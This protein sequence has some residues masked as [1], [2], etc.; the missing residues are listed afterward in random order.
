MNKTYYLTNMFL[1]PILDPI[2][3]HKIEFIVVG[4]DLSGVLSD[5][6]Q[7]LGYNNLS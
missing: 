1:D 5:I 7:I 3:I 2:D 6:K 4:N